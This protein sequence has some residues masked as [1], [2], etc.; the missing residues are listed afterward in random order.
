[1]WLYVGL[2]GMYVSLAVIERWVIRKNMYNPQNLKAWNT[3]LVFPIW[4]LMSF[5]AETVGTD[6]PVYQYLFVNIAQLP[7]G[8]CFLTLSM[9]K[10]FI[11][12]MYILSH[13]GCSFHVFQ[14]LVSTIT[15]LLIA[16]YIYRYSVNYALS[17]YFFI[18]LLF[19]ARSMNICRQML[20]VSLSVIAFQYLIDK[21][22]FRF[23]ISCIFIFFIHRTAVLQLCV[24]PIIFIKKERYRYFF[25]AL[26]CCVVYFFFYDIMELFIRIVGKYDYLIGSK[27]M[28]VDGNVAQYIN[29]LLAT[30]MC[31]WY[32]LSTK[33]AALLST[34]F[35][36]KSIAGEKYEVKV[37]EAY[38]MLAL[39]CSFI[40]LR[41]GLAD[42]A[43]LYFTLSFIVV[44]PN[45]LHKERLNERILLSIGLVAITG[46]YFIAVMLLRNNWHSIVPYMTWWTK[47]EL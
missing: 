32:C 42:R 41:F 6:T 44:L 28:C 33:K 4:F 14:V 23:T 3:F 20:A 5:R 37:W 19:L 34:I 43:A 26:L 2:I 47:Y 24:L 35:L 12:L 45:L 27:Y 1:M 21:K 16:L 13:L 31:G 29:I 36:K 15:C 46:V 39:I 8:Q 22:F 40:G 18:V 38:L 7:I 17:W 30:V 10:G 11:S 25:V 9:E